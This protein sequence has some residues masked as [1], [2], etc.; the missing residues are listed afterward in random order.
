MKFFRLWAVALL[1]GFL[2]VNCNDNIATLASTVALNE[3][4]VATVYETTTEIECHKKA[5]LNSSVVM[6]LSRG[7]TVDLAS[8]DDGA[9]KADGYYWVQV[10]PRLSQLP[11]SCY[12]AARYLIPRQ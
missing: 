10:Y 7:H 5:R 9:I 6:I 11:T 4:P 1:A 8:A 12:V 3:R 2:L